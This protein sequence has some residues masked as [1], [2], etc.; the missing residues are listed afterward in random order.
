MRWPL[1]IR[2]RLWLALTIIF[3]VGLVHWMRAR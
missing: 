1:R 2:V 3:F